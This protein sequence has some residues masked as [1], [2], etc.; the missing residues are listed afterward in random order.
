MITNYTD[1]TPRLQKLARRSG[2][3]AQVLFNLKKCVFCDL[4]KKYIIAEKDGLVL[5]VNLFPYLNY[6]LLLIPRRHLLCLGELKTKEWAAVKELTGLAKDLWRKAYGI[7]DFNFVYREGEKAGKTVWHLHFN[8][9]P[10]E[11]KLM[12]WRYQKVTAEPEKVARRLR[13]AVVCHLEPNASRARDPLEA[14]K[15]RGDFSPSTSLGVEMTKE[16]ISR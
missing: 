7:N 13:Q 6:H 9:F 11:R 4:K 8:L 14:T 5:V 12:E 2:E 1:Y 3:Y 16:L 15:A 10:Y